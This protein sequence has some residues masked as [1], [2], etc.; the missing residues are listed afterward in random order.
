MRRGEVDPRHGRDARAARDA[1]RDGARVRHPPLPGLL[2]GGL[3]APGA[4]ARRLARRGRRRGGGAPRARHRGPGG[5]GGEP[6]AGGR[7]ARSRAPRPGAGRRPRGRRAGRRR[8]RTH[9]L[10][11]RQAPPGDGGASLEANVRLVVRN[12]E[13]AARVA[14]ALSRREPDRR[15]R[16][17]DGRRGRA[18]RRAARA[19]E[20]LARAQLPPRGRPGGQHRGLAR[21]GGERPLLVGR[22]GD[23]ALGREAAPPCATAAW[24]AGWRSTGAPDGHLR[25]ARRGRRRADDAAGPR[26]ER[27]PRPETSR[28]SCWASA[29]TCTWPGTRCSGRA[30]EPPPAR[31]SSAPA[32]GASGVARPV[33]GGAAVAG[34][35]ELADGAGLLVPNAAEA[36]ALTGERD[37]ER[38]ARLWRSLGEVAVTLGSEGALW[39]DGHELVRV[40]AE[41]VRSWTARARATPSRPACWRRARRRGASRGA[42]GRCRLAAAAVATPGARPPIR[43]APTRAG[44]GERAAEEPGEQGDQASGRASASTRT[45]TP[46]KPTS[47]SPASPRASSKRHPRHRCRPRRRRRPRLTLTTA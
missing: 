29:L 7:A 24:N 14:A 38:A 44:G 11:A 34:F 3:G 10:P 31:R 41:P 43:R 45:S 26:R 42:R 23:D 32:S 17:R 6:P 25:R 13:L 15:A 20:R 1:E 21:G 28:T 30:R 33:L 35:L 46:A 47:R 40:A 2:P 37:P 12:A 18:A 4:L 5:G 36:T 9:A 16:R 22:V 27:R 39:T 19:G 8:A